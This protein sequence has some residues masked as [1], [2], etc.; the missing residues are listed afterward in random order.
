[1]SKLID[2]NRAGLSA[3]RR[4]FNLR[5]G[6]TGRFYSLPA[7]QEM[8]GAPIS[9]LPVSL[10]IVL[11]SLVRNCDG[12]AIT[13]DHVKALAAWKPQEP[14]NNEIPFVVARIIIPDSSGV[15][16]LADLA[17]MRDA[18]RHIGIDPGLIQPKVNVDLIIDHSAQVD[19][20]GTPDALEKNLELEFRRNAERYEFLKWAQ[21]AFSGLRV[22]PPGFGII[23]QINLEYLSPGVQH[24]GDLYFPD[25][26]VGADSHTPMINALGVVAWGVGGIEAD[27]GMLGEPIYFLTPDVVGVELK[28]KLRPGV[29]ATDAVLTIVERLR[30]AK[31]VGAFV[32]YFGEGASSLTAT[33][34]ATIANMTPE[35]GATIGFFPVDERTVDYYR[36]VGRTEDELAALVSYWQ[37]QSMWGIPARGDIDY[38]SVIEID[39]AAVEPSVAGPRRPQDRIPLRSLPAEFPKMLSQPRESGGFG[40]P[41]PKRASGNERRSV[42]AMT[43]GDIALAAITSCTNTSNPGLMIGAGLLARKA[44]ERGLTP[45]AWVKTSFSPGSRAVSGYLEQSGLQTYLDA[46]GFQPVGYGCMTCLGNSGP[47]QPMVEDQ[48]AKDDLVVAAVLSGNRNFEAR[49]HPAIRANFLMSPALVIAFALAGRIDLDVDREPLGIDTAGRPVMLADVWPSQEEIDKEL[50]RATSASLFRKVYETVGE[51]N[52]LW[53]DLRSNSGQ[54]FA[55]DDSSTYVKNPPFFLNFSKQAPPLRS[56]TG[57]RLLA[58]FG[59]SLTTDHISPGG[60]IKKTSPAGEYLIGKGIQPPDFNSYISRRGNHEVMMRGTFANVRIRNKLTPDDEGGVTIHQPSGDKLSIYDAAMR[61]AADQVPLVVIAGQEYGTGSS[62]DWAAKGTML[63]GVR[64]VI[65]KSFE[66][67]H[68][69]NLVGM[70]VLPCQF[71]A[72]F[73][74]ASLALTGR[75]TF[76]IL[77]VDGDVTVMQKARLRIHANGTSRDVPITVRID[78]PVEVEYYRNGGILPY[79]LRTKLLRRAKDDAVI[80]AQLR[81]G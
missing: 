34:R 16:L 9:R 20:S 68:R 17:A 54:T 80:S 22:V 15:P 43:D 51:G 35:T 66:R 7:L 53:R 26:L 38:S 70:G 74:I 69:G 77:D 73:D 10:R 24:R 3:C 33:D 58:M 5:N 81:G 49:I 64:A 23:H 30:A 19:F 8:S 44:V 11:E 1:M 79:V 72:D 12:K 29:T 60:S 62:R 78:T 14:R 2:E 40:R 65:A 55:W 39:L 36:S 48:V 42:D 56:I 67:I 57:A 52:G 31:I 59:D 25:S 6:E 21:Q 63:L 13:E 46:L 61:Y 76:D 41:L 75:E 47:L 50:H 18:A 28:K 37:A 27:A 4:H 71:D 45:P 32:E